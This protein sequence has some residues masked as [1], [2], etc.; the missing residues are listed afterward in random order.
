MSIDEIRFTPGVTVQDFSIA[1]N[2]DGEV[3][4]PE[5]F[6]VNVDGTLNAIVLTP[7]IQVDI[8]GVSVGKSFFHVS[9]SLSCGPTCM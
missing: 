6:Y 2:S 8:C 5:T 7:R 9:M 3:E 1:I 4:P